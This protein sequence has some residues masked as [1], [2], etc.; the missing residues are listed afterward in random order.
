M[1]V[2]SD[3]GGGG[4]VNKSA[5]GGGETEPAQQ[6]TEPVALFFGTHLLPRPSSEKKPNV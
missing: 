4:G 3:S 2:Y 6:R 1:S 5:G